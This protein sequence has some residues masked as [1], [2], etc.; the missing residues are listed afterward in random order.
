MLEDHI[1]SF[2]P[3]RVR[4]YHEGLQNTDIVEQLKMFLP[5]V[6]GIQEVR[7]N[8]R[9][10]SLLLIYDPE[11]FSEGALS[12]LLQQG[13]LLLSSIQQTQP[14]PPVSHKRAIKHVLHSALLL[15]LIGSIGSALWGTKASHRT[16]SWIFTVMAAWHTWQTR[17]RF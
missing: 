16:V 15:S 17:N 6:Q 9:I 1:T 14:V 7:I 10:G 11:C 4:L 8:P 5:T 3:G 2:I 13:E 12:E